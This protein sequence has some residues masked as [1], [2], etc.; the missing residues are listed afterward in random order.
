MNLLRYHV[1]DTGYCLASE[2]HLIRTGTRR[3]V[4]CH[5]IVAILEH[6][7]HGWFLWD[8][9]YAPRMLEA[10]RWLPFRL[11][12]WATPLRLDPKLAVVA[13]LARFGLTPA[14]IR[15]VI[16]SHFHA[17]HLCGLRDFPQ[18]RFV[19]TKSAVDDVARRRGWSALRRGLIPSLLPEDFAERLTLLPD[20]IGAPLG[21]LGPTHDFFGDGSVRFVML[22]G[23][24]HGQVGMLVQTDD[25]PLFFV[26]DGAWMSRAIR[27]NAPPHWLTHLIVDD[28]G[29][30]QQTLTQLHEFARAHP[31]VTMI[32]THCP[33]MFA[34]FVDPVS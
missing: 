5:S 3:T 16:V 2:H 4:H 14:D 21:A 19:A 22:P 33:E 30:M 23:H 13:Q 17:D 20:F 24:A 12:R 18:A 9:G 26:A 7:Q 31:E 32:P 29:A 28:A 25:G 34:R 8:T 15:S 27:E 10:T 11:Y 1:L 6:P